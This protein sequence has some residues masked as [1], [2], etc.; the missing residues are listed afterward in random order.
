M[1]GGEREAPMSAMITVDEALA[2]VLASADA[3]LEEEKIILDG[4]YGRVLTRDIRALR[5]QPPFANSAM[6]GYALRAADTAAAPSTLTVIGESAAGH[7]FS[8]AL[9]PGQA[10]RIFTGA[11]IPEGADAIVIQEDVRRE[12]DRI[13]LAAAAR[14]GE[15][16]RE[17]G[18]DFRAGETLIAAGRRLTPRDVALAA[19]ANHTHL[20][21]RRRARVA[22]LA[23]GDELV[24]P[25]GTLGPAQ[26]IASNNY[27]VAGVVEATGAIAIDL[28][29]A[30]DELGALKDA[31][32]RAREAGADVL[33]TLGG[34]SVGDYDLVQHAL[35]AEGM[36]LGFWRI[37]MR[38]GKPLM[39][40]RLG[41]MRILGLPGNPTS[42]TVCAVLFLRPLIRALHGEPDPGADL[43]QAGRL[44]VDLPANGPRQD[45]MRASLVRGPD[46]ILVATPAANQDSSL[47]KTMARADGLVV[48]PVRAEPAKA[49]DA[50]RVIPFHGLGV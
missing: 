2:R 40:G 39:H 10:V 32:R 47:V 41:A 11:P 5:I 22:I 17:A 23:T 44:A 21:V 49:G 25:G 35:V 28:G 20:P 36:E 37:A 4:A 50:C 27:A 15:N 45:Y 26:I 16:L 3:P 7:A 38:P 30:V 9:G 8:G 33:V 48:R 31:V 43:S 12:G 24:P 19:A 46:G 6:D 34:A 18:M 13:S 1:A 42:S 14:A 29:I